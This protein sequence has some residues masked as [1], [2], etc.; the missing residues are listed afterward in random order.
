[1]VESIGD[2]EQQ[3]KIVKYNQIPDVISTKEYIEKVKSTI[4]NTLQSAEE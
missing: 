1:M 2:D 4:Y 3:E